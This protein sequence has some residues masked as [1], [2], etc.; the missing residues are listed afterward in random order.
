MYSVEFVTTGNIRSMRGNFMAVCLTQWIKSNPKLF[1]LYC[2]PCISHWRVPVSDFISCDRCNRA[3]LSR[4]CGKLSAIHIWRR[5]KVHTSSYPAES[6]KASVVLPPVCL[7]WSPQ[8]PCLWPFHLPH[9]K[10][11]TFSLRTK[12]SSPIPLASWQQSCPQAALR[13][14]P[15]KAHVPEAAAS[16]RLGWGGAELDLV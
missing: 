7:F 3:S 8:D 10:P 15:S 6:E 11:R 1:S 14:A 16:K 9:P 5:Y 13:R 2:F 12:A 4:H